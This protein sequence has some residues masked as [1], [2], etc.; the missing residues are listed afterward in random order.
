M[1]GEWYKLTK[2]DCLKYIDSMLRKIEAVIKSREG[3]TKYQ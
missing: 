3:A 1:N 2:E